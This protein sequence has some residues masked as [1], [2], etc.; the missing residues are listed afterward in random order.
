MVSAYQSR[1]SLGELRERRLYLSPLAALR[2]SALAFSTAAILRGSDCR[3]C[4]LLFRLGL[5]R[6]EASGLAEAGRLTW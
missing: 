6:F 3:I 2:S 4:G 5:A 1:Y